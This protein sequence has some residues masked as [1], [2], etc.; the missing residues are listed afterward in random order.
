MTSRCK[1]CTGSEQH[2]S[3]ALKRRCAF[4]MLDGV[5]VFSSDNFQC[6]TLNKLKSYAVQFGKAISVYGC[7]RIWIL[8]YPDDEGWIVLT[9]HRPNADGVMLAVYLKEDRGYLLPLAVAEKAIE[10]YG[11]MACAKDCEV[12]P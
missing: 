1:L 2:Y 4:S 3:G 7:G 12:L 9:A 11:N 8:P 6:A 10:Y 5:L